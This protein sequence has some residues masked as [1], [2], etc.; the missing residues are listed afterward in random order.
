MTAMTI[1]HTTISKQS[2]EFL[3]PAQCAFIKIQE[4]DEFVWTAWRT[5]TAM[6]KWKPNHCALLYRKH[7]FGGGAIFF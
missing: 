1:S 6:N 4:Q 7:F 3:F 5:S 2:K